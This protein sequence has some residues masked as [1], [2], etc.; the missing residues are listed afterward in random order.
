MRASPG[1]GKPRILL[2]KV[3]QTLV[4][5]SL[6]QYHFFFDASDGAFGFGPGKAVTVI[7]ADAVMNLVDQDTI[8][9][10]LGP[11]GDTQIRRLNNGLITIEEL[12]LST[13]QL[14]AWNAVQEGPRLQ[15]AR[16]RLTGLPA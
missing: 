16:M 6:D 3:I 15:E 4:G 2:E 1:F 14:R 9:H 11:H 7:V 10:F 12:R 8:D 5:E 13:R